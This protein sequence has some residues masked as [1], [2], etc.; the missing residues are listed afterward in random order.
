LDFGRTYVRLGGHT[1]LS[2]PA[3]RPQ[4][5][6]IARADGASTSTSQEER[7]GRIETTFETYGRAMMSP[8]QTVQEQQGHL[9]GPLDVWDCGIHSSHFSH[10]RVSPS[11]R[12]SPSAQGSPRGRARL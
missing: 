10:G 6:R 4:Q 5:R 1:L 7:L 11:V 2:V 8:S 3:L 12:G 9:M